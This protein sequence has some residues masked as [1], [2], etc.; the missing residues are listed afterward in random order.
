MCSSFTSAA[1][2]VSLQRVSE[3]QRSKLDLIMSQTPA[4]LTNPALISELTKR[5]LHWGT[6]ETCVCS[7][8]CDVAKKREMKHL[9]H[10]AVEFLILTG[11]SVLYSRHSRP[12][13]LIINRST[14]D[15]CLIKKNMFVDMERFSV[16]RRSLQC[17][18]FI[19]I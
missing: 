2:A 19:R 1:A 16:R 13:T 18:H 8:Y 6:A 7:V 4:A 12:R 15:C 5:T 14:N 10:S 11:R 9:Y 3:G 17:Q